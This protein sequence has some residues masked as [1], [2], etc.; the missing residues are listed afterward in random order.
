MLSMGS[1][2]PWPE[3]MKV[4][5]GQDRMDASAF[6]EY[7]KPLEEWLINKNKELNETVGWSTGTSLSAIT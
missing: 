7:F 3:A 2:K 6:R 4:L 1:S 5:T